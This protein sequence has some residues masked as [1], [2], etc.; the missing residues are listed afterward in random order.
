M[1]DSFGDKD[2]M[3]TGTWLSGRRKDKG[4]LRAGS[5]DLRSPPRSSSKCCCPS[6]EYGGRVGSPTALPFSEAESQEA[7]KKQAAPGDLPLFIRLQA[8]GERAKES[9]TLVQRL[10]C[11]AGIRSSFSGAT[12]QLFKTKSA[13]LTSPESYCVLLS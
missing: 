9:P 13:L 8:G 4:P 11:N 3:L 6:G 7:E 2:A 12:M 1:Y 5:G 10:E